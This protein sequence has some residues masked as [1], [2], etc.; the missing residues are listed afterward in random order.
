MIDSINSKTS[1]VGALFQASLDSPITV[2]QD[3][4]VP[5][6]NNVFVRLV[7]AKSAGKIT[8]QSELELELDH[9]QFQGKSIPLKSSTYQQVGKSR[10]KETAQRTAIGTGIG[11]AIGA[12]AGGGKG[13]AIGAAIGAGG[14][15]A[16]QVF[17]H[18]KEVQVPSETKL[19]FKLAEPLEVTVQPGQGSK[20]AARTPAQPVQ[21]S[22][23]TE[24]F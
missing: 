20:T 18:G 13:A 23:P 7:N 21:E 12:I 8:G 17:I 3:V 19:D 1:Q 11:A 14:G 9:L 6:G 2:G 15:V 4:V 5:K 16:T 24:E 22:R 10:G